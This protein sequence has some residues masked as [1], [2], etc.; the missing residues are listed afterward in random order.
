META[1]DL[2]LDVAPLE[3]RRVDRAVE[4]RMDGFLVGR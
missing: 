4:D 1:V 3:H 2:Q